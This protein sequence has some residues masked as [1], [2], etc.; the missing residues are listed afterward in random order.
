MITYLLLA[1]IVLIGFSVAVVLYFKT[2]FNNLCFSILFLFG[3][4]V[5]FVYHTWHTID[6]GIILSSLCKNS[7]GTNIAE[8][9][10]CWTDTNTEDLINSY[11]IVTNILTIILYSL[12]IYVTAIAVILRP[13]KYWIILLLCSG[14]IASI[15]LAI[16]PYDELKWYTT[17]YNF[18][19]IFIL[20]CCYT[21]VAQRVNVINDNNKKYEAINEDENTPLTLS[22]RQRRDL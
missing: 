10:E 6:D 2:Q 22:L 15:L 7:T 3:F 20:L 9:T 11:E 17:V 19:N 1:L 4:V 16:L 13:V 12:G 18:Y 5:P 8:W 21:L 14:I